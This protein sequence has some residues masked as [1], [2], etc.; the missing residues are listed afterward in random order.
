MKL[1]KYFMMAA[2][3]LA[4]FACSNDEDIPGLNGEGT[5]SVY[6]KFEGLSTGTTTRTTGVA[7]SGGAIGF[8]NITVYFT[9]ASGVIKETQTLDSKV[10]DWSKLS[11]T[12]HLFHGIPNTVEKVYVV[13]NA[14]GKG[15]TGSNISDIK[16]Q[17]LQVANE[18]DFEDVIL[19]GA[20]ESIEP[21]T[22]GSVTDTEHPGG[23]LFKAE[24]TL[25]PFVSRFEIAGIQCEN[26]TDKYSKITLEA[27][28]LMDYNNKFT[29]GG[30]ASEEM[31]I[32]NILEPGSTAE[33][34]KYIFGEVSDSESNDYTNYKWA[35]DKISGVDLTENTTVH[36]P[37]TGEDRYVYQFCPLQ[38]G[39][40]G[41]K[42]NVQIKLAV[43][44]FLKGTNAKD[45][46][47]AV[48]TASFNKTDGKPL[49]AFQAGKIYKID[50]Y[51]FKVEN[52]KPWNPDEEICVNVVVKVQNWEVVA[53][54][55]V[56]E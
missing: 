55:P 44:A 4:L 52:V 41:S 42:K 48:V 22:D 18:Q 7:K 5:K 12:G 43:D 20:D 17:S 28:G 9:N 16:A 23:Y 51:K 33:P 32:A 14:E 29:V 56:F 45:P 54:T 15:L 36:Y 38:I 8:D 31:T 27:I 13:G 19:F 53:L 34:G 37:S 50:S 40:E 2:A 21:V 10:S 6:L 39:Q 3:S 25:A 1:S 24:V 49:E 30:T 46:F 26:L 47:G 35:W 11:T